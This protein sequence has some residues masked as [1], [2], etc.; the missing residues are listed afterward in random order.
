VCILIALLLRAD[1]LPPD[2]RPNFDELWSYYGPT[3]DCIN[4]DRHIVY[5]E[6]LKD[7]PMRTGDRVTKK[8]YDQAIDMYVERMEWYCE[9]PS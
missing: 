3:P 6:S 1:C 8:Q 5:L 2:P 4:R 9:K 7:K